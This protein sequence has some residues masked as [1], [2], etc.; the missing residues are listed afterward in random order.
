GHATSNSWR[1][2]MILLLLA[3]AFV[4][5]ATPAS[6]FICPMLDSEIQKA[7]GNRFDAN[8]TRAK[9]LAAEG[10]ALHRARKHACVEAPQEFL[11]AAK[12]A[13]ITLQAEQRIIE[14]CQDTKSKYYRP[15]PK[16]DR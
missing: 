15:S 7:V 10:M 2:L 14:T 16:T 13:G 11:E 12:V 1:R 3:L 9:E 6:A 4:L 8:A 5:L